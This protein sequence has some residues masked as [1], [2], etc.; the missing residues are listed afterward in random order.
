MPLLWRRADAVAALT[1]VGAKALITCG[2]V[3]S[4]NHC[5]LAMRVAADVFSIRYVC[6]FGADL[7]DGVVPF[8]DLFTAEKLDP[9]PPLDRERASN[10]AAHL[11]AITFDVG[12]AG[13]VPVA[14]SHL[15]LLAGGLGVLLES[16]LVQDARHAVDDGASIVRRH[17]SDAAAVAAQRRHASC[18]IIPSIRRCWSANGAAMTAAARWSCP[19]PVAFRLAEAGV[20]A[21][22]RP[23]LRA[24]A[25]GV[26][27][28]GS[29]ASPIGASATSFWSTCR[30]SARSGCVAAR[31][32]PSRPAGAAF[33]SAAVVAPRGSHR[34]GRGRRSD[35]NGARH[36][37]A[38][39]TDGAASQFSARRRT[40]RAAAFRHRPRRPGRYR[41]YLPAR[42]RRPD[43]WRSPA[44]PP[45]IVNVGG[46]RFPL[47]D[48]QDTLGQIDTGAT[49]ATLPD[50]VLGQRLVGNAVDR[51]AVQAALNAAGVNPI[52]AE[53]FVDRSEG[54]S[55]AAAA[56]HGGRVDAP[57]TAH[58]LLSGGFSSSPHPASLYLTMALQGPFVVVADSPA[59]DV[60][61]A[62][63]AEGAFPIIETGWADAAAALAS[64]EPE[65]MVLA[66]PCGDQTRAAALAKALAASGQESTIAPSRRSSPARATTARAD[67]PDALAIAANAPVERHQSPAHRG[68]AHPHAARHGAAPHRDARL[69]RR[70]AARTAVERSARRRD[71]AARSAAAAPIRRSPSRSAN[72]SA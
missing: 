30:F 56:Q 31:R 18:C 14:R 27:R 32:G 11:A 16:R 7:P 70:V 40:L 53:A 38:A 55:P 28:S 50:P 21:R 46:Y 67:L 47:H 64:V 35:G 54:A 45:G 48:L 17:L 19:A 66:E 1:R 49:L 71:R 42:S 36:R 37:G 34:R 20:F 33:R 26:R 9:V 44:P 58:W 13:I 12:E 57:L 39:R 24:G 3:G 5:Q 51:Y 25:H 41:L 72:A 23:G 65:A 6:G 61:A 69:A 4:F 63:R 52:V 15:E 62:L 22:D 10:A 43:R 59:A 60:V 8:D 68:A 29:A 2:R